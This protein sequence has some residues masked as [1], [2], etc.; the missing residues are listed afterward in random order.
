MPAS[1]RTR[2]QVP[3]EQDGA[4][5]IGLDHVPPPF[6]VGVDERHPFA[7][8]AGHVDER[9]DAAV[10]DRH[11]FGQLE[12][13]GGLAEVGDHDPV[14]TREIGADDGEPV[15]G[16][17]CGDGAP[18]GARGTRHQRDAR[19]RVGG[20]RPGGRSVVETCHGVTTRRSMATAV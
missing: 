14:A 20:H 15:V 16:Q 6:R 11:L 7:V 17:P 12:H 8:G 5:Q 13:L 4:A 9:V 19:R 1:R 2:D 10:L 3:A 18:D